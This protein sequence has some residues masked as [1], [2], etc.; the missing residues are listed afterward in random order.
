MILVTGGTGLVGS[1]LLQELTSQG[2][3][4]RALRR[5]TSDT[6]FVEHV[7]NA[8]A[9]NPQSQLSAIEWVDGD[10]LDLFS[11]EDA[12][13]GVSKVYHNAAVVS[14][15]PGDRD[16]MQK[17]NV[18]GTANVVNAALHKGI[19]KL[20]HLSSIAALGRA[21]EDGTT[22]ETTAWVTSRNN[23]YYAI[24]KFNGEREVW[25][26]TEEGL[27]AVVLLPSVILGMASISNGSMQLFNTIL[28]GLPFYTPGS[29]G[30][31]DVR[32][33]A[34]AQLLLMDSGVKN[35]KFV[36]SGGNHS[37]QE[38]LGMIAKGLGKRPPFIRVSKPM[39][40]MAWNFF[41]I[42]SFVTGTA[43]IITRETANTAMQEYRY[44]NKKLTELTKMKF[45]NINETI[46]DLCII[47]K[48]NNFF[49]K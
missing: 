47:M 15:S 33:V 2:I 14:F 42:K 48:E 34:K 18:E 28:K 27:D 24:S 21:N 17:V 49:R 30:F 43:P 44:S 1:H 35:E 23:S 19:Q 39:A 40:M 46:R 45:R 13:T 37:Y 9:D 26:G 25:R 41:R 8:Y 3:K 4:V 11:L 12:M 5:K 22:D 36:V 6:A 29:N 32:D 10:V 31:V 16:I 38:V 20:C 7:F